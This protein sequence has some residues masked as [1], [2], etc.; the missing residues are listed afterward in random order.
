MCCS[1]PKFDGRSALLLWSSWSI[2]LYLTGPPRRVS[3]NVPWMRSMDDCHENCTSLLCSVENLAKRAEKQSSLLYLHLS[4]TPFFFFPKRC[5]SSSAILVTKTCFSSASQSPARRLFFFQRKGSALYLAV[6]NSTVTWRGTVYMA[7][8]C[9]EVHVRNNTSLR[10]GHSR[11]RFVFQCM[12][13]KLL[14]S[15]VLCF[16]S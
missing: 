15:G 1:Q 3:Y 10:K 13:F 5:S 2:I 6:H 11:E 4:N 14:Y 9:C 12:H 16:F 7:V 8:S